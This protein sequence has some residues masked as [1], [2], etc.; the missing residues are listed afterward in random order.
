MLLDGFFDRYPRFRQHAENASISKLLAFMAS[1]ANIDRMI[2]LNDV[3]EMAPLSAI[4][5]ELEA[6]FEDC[7]DFR[8]LDVRQMIGSMIKDVLA[9]FGYEPSDRTLVRN[10]RYFK[11]SARYRKTGS[12][13]LA[14]QKNFGIVNIQQ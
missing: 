11:V 9:P 14:L 4:V 1:P 12:P 5:I 10:S 7:I 3:A 2:L 6:Q 8:S 13:T